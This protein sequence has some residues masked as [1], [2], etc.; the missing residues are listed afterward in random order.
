M[1]SVLP[2]CGPT[3]PAS[4]PP[5]TDGK[6]LPDR[7]RLLA[8]AAAAGASS[9]GPRLLMHQA[10]PWVRSHPVFLLAMERLAK[11]G[12]DGLTVAQAAAADHAYSQANGDRVQGAAALGTVAAW[13]YGES[14]PNMLCG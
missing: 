14:S 6:T 8:A 10:P 1:P 12:E 7:R 9:G 4:P 2:Q 13:L 5:D 11:D 3:G